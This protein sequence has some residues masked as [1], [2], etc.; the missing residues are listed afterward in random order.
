MAE[1]RNR[2]GGIA[3]HEMRDSQQMPVP[4]GIVKGIGLLGLGEP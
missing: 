1:G 3:I 2:L 4:G